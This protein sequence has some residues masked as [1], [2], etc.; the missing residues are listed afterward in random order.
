VTGKRAF[1]GLM[2]A[3]TFAAGGMATFCI[4]RNSMAGA[5]LYLA[6]AM[7]MA[8]FAMAEAGDRA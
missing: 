2:T 5:L 8:V 3:G 7:A 1:V 6:C 4:Q